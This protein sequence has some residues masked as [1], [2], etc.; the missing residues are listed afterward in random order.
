V[1]SK[2]HFDLFMNIG[3]FCSMMSSVKKMLIAIVVVLSAF[4]V[5]GQTT[6][7]V[8]KKSGP[9]Y[10]LEHKV[11]AKENWYSIGRVYL[12][13]P[14]VI[15]VFNELS[16]DKGLS[17]GQQIKIPL[18]ADNFNQTDNAAFTGPA[19]V[20]IVAQGEGLL[21]LSNVYKVTMAQLR[22]W[23]RLTSDQLK[24]NSSLIIGFLQ[25]PGAG[26]IQP[27]NVTN[28][29]NQPVKNLP[30]EQVLKSNADAERSAQ[31][32]TAQRQPAVNAS[33]PEK[34]AQPSS[35]QQA[36]APVNVSASSSSAAPTAAATGFF[37]GVFLSQSKEGRQQKMETPAYGVFKSTSGWQDSKYYVLMNNVVPGTVIRITSRNTGRQIFAKVLGAVPPGKESEGLLLRISNAAASALGVPNG[38]PGVFELVW[39]N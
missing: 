37:S 8:I 31:R 36:S 29:D 16:M 10:Y 25:A 33:G 22:E 5:S 20:H 28:K 19:I 39:S 23:N 3:L 26:N 13:S 12:L 27:T 9:D 38:E 32:Q 14:K 17:I 2:E 7:F 18:T 1:P 4:N 21:R 15:S 6:Q 11:Q 34:S 30:A 35:V 24:V